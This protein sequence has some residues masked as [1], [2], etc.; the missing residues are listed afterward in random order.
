MPN[1]LYKLKDN[2]GKTFYGFTEVKDIR[3]LKTRVRQ[4]GAYFISA[5]VFSFE[6]FKKE[7]VSF[8][9]LL[10][11]THRLTSLIESGIPILQA[12]SILWK[13]SDEKTI[14]LVTSRMYTHVENGQDISTAFDEFP[15]IFPYLYRAMVR[16]GEKTGAMVFILRKIV[17]H[18]E[19][20]RQFMSRLKKAMMY[21]CIVM[22]LTIL[23]LIGMFTFV[24]PTFQKVLM[25]L[26]IELP[27]LTR[28]VLG[29]STVIRNPVFITLVGILIAGAIITYKRMRQVP[30]M[31][32]K[33]DKIVLTIPFFG[34]LFL[35]MS[36][37]RFINSLRI[38]IAA[39]L[40]IVESLEVAKSTLTNHYITKHI[41]NIREGIKQGRSLY[42]TFRE[43]KIFPV[44]LV[45]MIGI[46]EK[47]GTVTK[48]LENLAHH[49]DEEV[50]YKLNKFLTI[51]RS[52]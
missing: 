4:F 7:K 35:T 1:Y 29:I 3:E 46:G 19:Y 42:E 45:E 28:L 12:L 48:I 23:V 20:Q 9:T 31:G 47:V 40:P 33:I 37:S 32:Y 10:M 43:T 38:L 34:N 5:K 13:Q 16:V 24:V 6:K 41:G 27:F 22:G 30:E 18:L 11:F 36:V 44:L 2:D 26:N 50:D 25:G 51:I 14:Q 15:N 39:G 21:P 17:E 8:D 52:P 49:F